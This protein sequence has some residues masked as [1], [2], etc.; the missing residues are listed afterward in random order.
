MAAFTTNPQKPLS[1]RAIEPAGTVYGSQPSVRVPGGV[2]VPMTPS[3]TATMSPDSLSKVGGVPKAAP[4]AGYVPA[5]GPLFTVTAYGKAPKAA[6]GTVPTRSGSVG[7][8]MS[9]TWRPSNPWP[10]SSPSQLAFAALAA[11]TGEFHD[12]TRML[13]HTAMSPWFP[14]VEAGEHWS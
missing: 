11:L 9:N 3:L 12:R 2:P 1:T 4:V 10:T 13:P 14:S 6:R 5:A 8:L 7:S